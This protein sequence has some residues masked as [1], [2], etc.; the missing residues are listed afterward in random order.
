MRKMAEIALI[1]GGILLALFVPVVPVWYAPVV[2]PPFQIYRF[3]LIS[4]FQ[5][6]FS[7]F[8]VGVSYRWEWYTPL[9]M[10][11]TLAAGFALGRA[12]SKA[13]FA[14]KN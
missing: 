7:M 3:E 5:A 14:R 1:V 9:V 8:L 11:L 4:I 13:L 12:V 10:L 6:I 2:P